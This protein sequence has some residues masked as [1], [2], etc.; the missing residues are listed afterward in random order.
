M[1]SQRDPSGGL[2]IYL[3]KGM[4]REAPA[5]AVTAAKCVDWLEPRSITDEYCISLSRHHACGA[6]G[7]SGIDLAARLE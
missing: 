5:L 3:E 2:S 6:R 1:R 4:A 7:A